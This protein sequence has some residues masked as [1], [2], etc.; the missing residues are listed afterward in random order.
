MPCELTR[1][2]SG[3]PRGHVAL[4]VP[5]RA[6]SPNVRRPLIRCTSSRQRRR[7]VASLYRPSPSP[8]PLAR[9]RADKFPIRIALHAASHRC[10]PVEYG[11]RRQR[12][13]EPR[14]YGPD[15]SR[16]PRVRMA[17][18]SDSPRGNRSSAIHF[19]ID[20]VMAR[21]AAE[22][23]RS[24]SRRSYHQLFAGDRPLIYLRDADATARRRRRCLPHA[25]TVRPMVSEAL[26]IRNIN[27]VPPYVQ[28]APGVVCSGFGSARVSAMH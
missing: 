14:V 24:F 5:Y 11:G 12:R 16:G 4:D 26:V 13:G 18:I 6:F 21:G 28:T 2:V 19:N 10:A 17:R 20:T 27:H 15:L 22:N 23:R 9:S 7:Y 25:R 1:Y 8:L 3:A